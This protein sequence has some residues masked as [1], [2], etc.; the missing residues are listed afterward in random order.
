M[1]KNQK[2]DYNSESIVNEVENLIGNNKYRVEISLNNLK[3]FIKVNF[4]VS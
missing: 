3:L 2:V 4:P 1:K